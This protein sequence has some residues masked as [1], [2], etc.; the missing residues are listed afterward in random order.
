MSN[1][2]PPTPHQETAALIAALS[3]NALRRA[4]S[5]AIFQRG[6]TYATSG[7]VQV[8]SEEPGDTPAIYAQVI[9]GNTYE[10]EVWIHE[11]K[12]EGACDCANAQDGWFCKHQVA[13]ALVWRD[14]LS[15]EVPAVDDE[16]RMKV[17]AGVKR[18]R[19]AQD[20]ARLCETS[21]KPR[22]Q[23]RWPAGC[24]TWPIAITRSRASCSSGASS[25]R[26]ATERPT[27]RC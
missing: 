16:A 11:G 8:Q 22:T 7:A 5:A 20:R 4:S 24:S 27:R 2:E 21:C 18:A 1:T 19:T 10:T 17:Q 13:L 23:R 3:D 25:A 9:G 26:P 12:V 6:K 14:R 15:G